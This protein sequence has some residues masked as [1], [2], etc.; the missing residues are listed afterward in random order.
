M[1]RATEASALIC[2]CLLLAACSTEQPP[3]RSSTDLFLVEVVSLAGISSVRAPVNITDRPGYDN[4]PAFL[5]D[6]SAILY[7]ARD[8]AD[9]GVYRYDLTSGAGTRLTAAAPY[10]LYS[11]QPIPGSDAFAAVQARRT[12]ELLLARFDADGANPEAIK[13]LLHLDVG[14][15]AWVDERMVAVRVEGERPEL[16]L[17]DLSSGQLDVIVADIGRSIQI[18][19]GRRAISFVHKESE[20]EWWIKE[21]DLDSREVIPLARTLQGKEDHAWLSADTLLMARGTKIFA[22][23]TAGSRGWEP[24]ADF[25]E[26][27]L[28]NVSRIAVSPE[29][30]RIVVVAESE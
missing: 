27:G 6:G 15:H 7:V 21:L 5:A 28:D 12:G 13:A 14:Y 22:H 16:L 26:A 23:R 17:A 9:M 29:G 30:D 3:P 1:N 19:P 8:A 2:A 11:P 10:R 20:S 24:F 25:A 4:Q 18:I